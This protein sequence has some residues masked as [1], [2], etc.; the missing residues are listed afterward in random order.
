MPHV[1]SIQNVT[2][3]C[4]PEKNIQ[5]H[6]H[7]EMLDQ[8]FRLPPNV[9]V[10]FTPRPGEY[11][12]GHDH[13][14]GPGGEIFAWQQDGDARLNLT[15]KVA[16]A[17][18][19]H[20]RIDPPWFLSSGV[21]H[22]Y[23]P[24]SGLPGPLTRFPG[25]AA[26][27][28]IGVSGITNAS[29]QSG[30]MT[31]DQYKYFKSLYKGGQLIQNTIYIMSQQNQQPPMSTTQ[32][33]GVYDPTDKAQYENFKRSQEKWRDNLSLGNW[34]DIVQFPELGQEVTNTDPTLPT[35]ATEETGIP[36]LDQDPTFG[37]VSGE[38]RRVT[39][40]QIIKYSKTW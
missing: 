6:S 30:S 9:C 37:V 35:T 7:G 16:S 31:V 14:F 28:D 29:L 36:T 10:L 34:H 11:A 18:G 5:I 15:S 25:T 40:F 8:V 24:S 1:P 4:N 2:K 17:D 38:A 39:L 22:D 23:W 27:Q 19:Y 26:V 20:Q 21:N 32:Q 13:I 33:F 3:D 12:Y